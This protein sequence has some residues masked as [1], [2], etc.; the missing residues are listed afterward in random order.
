MSTD[1]EAWS[2][3]LSG[4]GESFGVIFDRHQ[5]RVHRHLLGLA[6]TPS[7]VDDLVAVTFLETWRKRESVRFVDGSM[8]PWLLRTATYTAKNARRSARRYRAALS[9]LP[10]TEDHPDHADNI[11]DGDAMTALREL[12]A[13][14]Q[15]VITLCVIEGVSHADAA[16][17]LGV[18]IGTVKSR[19]SRAKARMREALGGSSAGVAAEGATHVS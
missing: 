3:A 12:S 17:V 5:A 7:D 11:G 13:A 15:Q 9:R 4:D 10:K 1:E 19:L 6:A 8:L 18:R 14:D 2:A 16:E